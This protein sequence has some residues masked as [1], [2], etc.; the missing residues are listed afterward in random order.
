MEEVLYIAAHLPQPA[1]S[2]VM[3]DADHFKGHQR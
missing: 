2:F 1:L 3:T